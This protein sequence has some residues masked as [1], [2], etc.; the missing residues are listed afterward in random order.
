MNA[1]V[2][3][4]WFCDQRGYEVVED[5]RWSPIPGS[6]VRLLGAATNSAGPW[7][8]GRSGQ[9]RRYLLEGTD[10]RLSLELANTPCTTDGALAFATR[11]GLLIP[12]HRQR[13]REFYRTVARM[14]RA[15][16]LIEGAN[17]AEL[18]ALRK[19]GVSLRFRIGRLTGDSTSR[20]FLD[21]EIL[22]DF[23]WA[24]FMQL[25]DGNLVVRKCP[26]CGK[27]LALGKVG[28]QPTH[29]SAACRSGMYR[30]RK[31]EKAAKK[32][33]KELRAL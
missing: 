25:V 28:K 31:R 2:R 1:M 24:E 17:T 27:L 7:L 5:G 32:K 19:D 6:E 29:C 15:A 22:R 9:K 33:L 20:T 26:R 23:C 18:E 8:V 14:K 12:G 16:I 11:W 4:D 3:L 21:A 10:N 13:L 30:E